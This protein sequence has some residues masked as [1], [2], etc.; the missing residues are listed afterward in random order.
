[1]ASTPFSAP[2]WL[3]TRTAGVLA[4]VSSLPGPHGIGSLGAGARVFVD[5]LADAGFRHWQVCPVGPTGYGDSPYQSFSSFA[6]NPYFIDLEE[7][8]SAGLVT[9]AELAPLRELPEDRVDYGGLYACFRPVLGRALH[10]F[11]QRGDAAPWGGPKALAAFEAAE[12]GWLDGY[13]TFMA[14]KGHFG[15]QPWTDWPAEWRDWSPDIEDRLPAAVAAK[16][17]QE[18]FQQFLFRRQWAALREYAN[19]RGVAI[20]G[21]VPIFVAL[22]SAD[23]WCWRDMFRLD[24]RGRPKAV[25]G[26]PPDYF[27]AAGQLWGNPLYDWE[28]LA[29]TGYTWWIARLQAVFRRCDIVRLDHFR[30]FETFWEIPIGSPDARTGRWRQGP[31]AAFFDAVRA[32][33]PAARVIAED[34]GYITAD[35]A[36]LRRVAGL[37]GMKILQF[38]YGHDDNNVNLPHFFTAD[39][40]VYTGTHDNDTTRG[41]LAGLDAEAFARV[42]DYFGLAGADTAWPLIR[43]AF[44]SVARL[45]IVP[46]QDLLDLPSSARMNRPGSIEGNWRWR[47]SGA[48]LTL[49]ERTRLDTLRHWHALFD[50][51]GDGRQRD[52]SA[53]PERLPATTGFHP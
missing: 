53:P 3:T 27:S 16:A 41:W 40:V 46:M 19:A 34:L 23:T 48:D 20:V 43:A 7:L 12:A 13:A 6:G 37:P 14:L 49:L 22:D 11:R 26:V 50:R 10:R 32:A 45:A 33:L 28:R 51:T 44:A 24:A 18:R 31:G 8:E 52:Y 38:G 15:G 35:V 1:M 4:H 9:A 47:F 5:F 29:A 2:T 21:D 39:T 42:A 36:A 17:E 25:A 30:G